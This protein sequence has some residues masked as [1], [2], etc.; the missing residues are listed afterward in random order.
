MQSEYAEG[1][2]RE[3]LADGH[4]GARLPERHPGGRTRAERLGRPAEPA[5]A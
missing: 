5:A 4:V 2:L 3:K 1:T